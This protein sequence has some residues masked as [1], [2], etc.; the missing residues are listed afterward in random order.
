MMDGV[1][2]T[3]TGLT[4]SASRSRRST[5]TLAVCVPLAFG[6][7]LT[8]WQPAIANA[9]TAS[10]ASKASSAKSASNN[11]VVRFKGNICSSSVKVNFKGTKGPAKGAK[12]SATLP[13]GGRSTEAKL[14]LRV[15][16]YRVRFPASV[17]SDSC[18]TYTKTSS[19]KLVVKRGKRAAVSVTY[20]TSLSTSRADEVLT[21]T[22]RVRSTSQVCGTTKYKPAAP[23]K[24]NSLLRTSAQAHSQDMADHNYFDH[25]NLKGQ[26]P[27]DRI[28]ATGYRYWTAGENIAAG[29]P[30][31][32]AVVQAWLDSPGH[33]RNMMDPDFTELGVGVANGGHYGIYWTQ[34]FG[35]RD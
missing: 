4:S 26:S 25:T 21:L 18:T 24:A 3:M 35:S 33:C 28:T 17:S 5:A 1:A 13:A 12:R 16:T 6:L 7:G 9:Q 14:K 34:N 10:V 2:K 32:A 19:K 11:V 8:L 29:Q 22:N 31:P 23:L 30:T 27:F 20:S 15:G